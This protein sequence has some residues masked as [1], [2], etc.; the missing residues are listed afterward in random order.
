MWFGCEVWQEGEFEF[1]VLHVP[2]SLIVYFRCTWPLQRVHWCVCSEVIIVL[3]CS[4]V[5][6]FFAFEYSERPG[7][8]EIKD[9]S[10]LM[11]IT[12]LRF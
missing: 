10:Y 1:T 3:K 12:G 7:C 2:L 11:C 6:F 8:S 5:V 9:V 4:L